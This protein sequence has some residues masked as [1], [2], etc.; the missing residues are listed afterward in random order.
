MHFLTLVSYFLDAALMGLELSHE[1]LVLLQ[2]P[3]LV[4]KACDLSLELVSIQVIRLLINPH[5]GISN[6][7]DELGIE[8]SILQLVLADPG[9][10][11]DRDSQI[12]L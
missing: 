5:V 10:K 4:V 7:P 1:C 12:K 11:A 3:H 2:L 9:G 6:I 8:E